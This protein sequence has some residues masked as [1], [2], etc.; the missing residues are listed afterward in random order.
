MTFLVLAVAAVISPVAPAF[1]TDGN[2]I[3]S[4]ASGLGAV[5]HDHDAPP[6]PT[7]TGAPAAGAPAATA[8]AT[9]TPAPASGDQKPAKQGEEDES[10]APMGW[11]VGVS[12]GHSINTANFLNPAQNSADSFSGSL[13]VGP[14]YKFTVSDIKLSASASANV[15]WDYMGKDETGRRF[16]WSDLGLRLSAPGNW[17]E[18]NTEI[19]FSPSFGLV[20]PITMESWTATLITR[21]SLS[22]GLSRAV[23]KFNFG[24][25]VGGSRGF[26]INQVAAAGAPKNAIEGIWG[27][28]LLRPGENQ[29]GGNTSTAWSANVGANIGFNATDELSFGLGFSLSK[30]WHYAV[31]ND[32]SDP[33]NTKA[34]DVNGRPVA[35]VGMAQADSMMGSLSVNY[36]LTEHFGASLAMVTGG[37]PLN[38]SNSGPN[39]PFFSFNGAAGGKTSFSLSL[40]ANY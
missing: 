2:G 18:P 20:I 30:S 8:T 28:P 10:T 22:L 31:T 9:G 33:Y 24:L 3:S 4:L 29:E 39:F 6:A 15:G 14:A 36:A 40:S 26:H 37:P 17:K 25:S 23:G 13:S 35:V 19:S 1:V 21:L 12:L 27:G 5:A 11:S 16:S 34:T 32:P 38:P 7:T